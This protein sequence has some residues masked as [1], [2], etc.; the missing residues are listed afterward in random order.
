MVL[1]FDDV[2]F[3]DSSEENWEFGV[4]VVNCRFDW[5]GINQFEKMGGVEVI[6]FLFGLIYAGDKHSIAPNY[7]QN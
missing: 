4:N 6:F 5:G 2:S 7:D 3:G 1:H